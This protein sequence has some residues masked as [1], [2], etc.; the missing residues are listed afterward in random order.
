MLVLDEPDERFEL[1]VRPTRS[2]DAVV[3]LD[4]SRDTGESWVV[5]A[6]RRRLAAAVGRRPPARRASTTPSTARA[7]RGR[8][9]LLL[10]TNDDAVEFRLMTARCRSDADQDHTHLARGRAPRTPTSGSSGSTPSPGASC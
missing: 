5:D 8:A 4:E 9:D 3:L 6:A 2:G 1:T 10:V 7:D